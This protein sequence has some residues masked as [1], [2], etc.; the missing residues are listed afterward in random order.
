MVI[1]HGVSLVHGTVLTC[2]QLLCN[3]LTVLKCWLFFYALI[4]V[5]LYVVARVCAKRWAQHNRPFRDATKRVLL[6]TAHPDDECEWLFSSWSLFHFDIY[7]GMFFA[8]TIQCLTADPRVHFHLL[9]LSTGE[10]PKH[11][12]RRPNAQHVR[13]VELYEVR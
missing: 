5:T 4:A 2:L 6:V 7:L 13:K 10:I 9:C 8:P 1:A 11:Y 12:R 3:L